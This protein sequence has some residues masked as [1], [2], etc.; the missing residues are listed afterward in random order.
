MSDE[1]GSPLKSS[2]PLQKAQVKVN[3]CGDFVIGPDKMC[4]AA[5][6]K[7]NDKIYI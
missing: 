7:I 1:I 4:K 5:D 3:S 6:N 2:Y